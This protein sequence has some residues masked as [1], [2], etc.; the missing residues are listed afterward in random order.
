MSTGAAFSP[1]LEPGKSTTPFLDDL[2]I[3]DEENRDLFT[4]SQ[5][6]RQRLPACDTG[7]GRLTRGVGGPE[8]TATVSGVSAK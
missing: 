6:P 7:A 1:Y 2:V 4:V 5:K 8:L 3:L